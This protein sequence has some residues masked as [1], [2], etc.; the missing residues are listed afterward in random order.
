[1]CK[2]AHG[3]FWFCKARYLNAHHFTRE[4]GKAH[5]QDGKLCSCERNEQFGGLTRNALQG[6]KSTSN[7]TVRVKTE[8]GEC[9]HT[10][11]Y[12][13]A[14]RENLRVTENAGCAWDGNVALREEARGRFP[15]VYS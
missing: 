4:L 15:P 5:P 8:G 13:H 9:A 7:Y 1:M 12:L 2:I 10:R 3:N 6:A 11:V 14:H